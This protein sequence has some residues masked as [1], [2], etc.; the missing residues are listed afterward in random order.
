MKWI[1]IFLVKIDVMVVSGNELFDFGTAEIQSMY[2]RFVQFRDIEAFDVTDPEVPIQF[3]MHTDYKPDEM[4]T[5][6]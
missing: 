5:I 2:D 3:F 1:L 4:K 6:S